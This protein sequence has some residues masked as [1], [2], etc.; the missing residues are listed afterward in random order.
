MCLGSTTQSQKRGPAQ[1]YL[2]RIFPPREVLKGGKGGVCPCLIAHIPARAVAS[3]VHPWRGFSFVDTPRKRLS[4]LYTSHLATAGPIM[5]VYIIPDAAG[6][7]RS[8]RLVSSCLLLSSCPSISPALRALARV[9]P[10]CRVMRDVGGAQYVRLCY[11]HSTLW[12]ECVLIARSGL[13]LG[14]GHGSRC[15]PVICETSPPMHSSYVRKR[16]S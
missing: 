14:G 5:E 13:A 6:L 16:I 4:R 2:S 1:R 3:R 15:T 8:W 10:D 7:G 11:A 12:V 9:C